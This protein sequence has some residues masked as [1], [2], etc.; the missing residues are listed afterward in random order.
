MGVG[1]AQQLGRGAVAGAAG[2]LV[3]R[4]QRGQRPALAAPVRDPVAV[5]QLRPEGA[6]ALAARALEVASRPVELAQPRRRR[7]AGVAVCGDEPAALGGVGAALLIERVAAGA[8]EPGPRPVPAFPVAA[9]ARD[10]LVERGVVPR[11][12]LGELGAQRHDLVAVDQRAVSRLEHGQLRLASGPE[13]VA[14]HRIEQ[15]R[16]EAIDLPAAPEHPREPAQVPDGAAGD[17]DHQHAE[18]L[19]AARL[20]EG[21]EIDAAV[22]AAQPGH[23]LVAGAPRQRRRR[24][25]RER[26]GEPGRQLRRRRLRIEADDH[27]RS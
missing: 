23:Q 9:V 26:A 2:R 27:P 25:G 22:A 14:G 8:F 19:A 4:V 6:R 18:H 16:H 5:E 1:G 3:G 15:R 10:Q 12:E 13:G 17:L 11:V 24:P 7:R 21:R 20:I